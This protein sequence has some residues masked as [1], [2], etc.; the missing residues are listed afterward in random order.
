MR[1]QTACGMMPSVAFTSDGFTADDTTST[2]TCPGP[3]S[4]IGISTT[5]SFTESK[6]S[7]FSTTQSARVPA[8]DF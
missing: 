1:G 4:G 2:S 5:S 6:P 3:G 8:C 7:A